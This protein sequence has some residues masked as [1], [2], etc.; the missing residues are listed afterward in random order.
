MHFLYSL[1]TVFLGSHNSPN[2]REMTPGSNEGKLEKL[3]KANRFAIQDDIQLRYLS[4]TLKLLDCHKGI[5]GSGGTRTRQHKTYSTKPK[6]T[7]DKKKLIRL[8]NQQTSQKCSKQI[9]L[10]QQIRSGDSS[11]HKTPKPSFR[12]P[13]TELCE[14]GT[15]TMRSRDF[16]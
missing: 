4:R 7:K 10:G 13:M 15:Q 11:P 12:H 6:K 3:Q 1:Q 16:H 14:C 9:A 5:Q 8:A 2:P